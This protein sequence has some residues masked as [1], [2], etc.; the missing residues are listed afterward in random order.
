V[1]H[2]RPGLGGSDTTGQGR[3]PARA[4]GAAPA[5]VERGATRAAPPRAGRCGPG[6]GVFGAAARG[7]LAAA[8]VR[9]E[10]MRERE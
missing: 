3:G 5:R 6:Q 9:V 10:A 2:G 7:D 1:E 4:T 8:A